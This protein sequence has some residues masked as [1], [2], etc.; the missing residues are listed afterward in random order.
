ME[1]DDYYQSLF[2]GTNDVPAS[3]NYESSFPVQSGLM[4]FKWFCSPMKLKVMV[5]CCL[6]G[7]CFPWLS[8]AAVIDK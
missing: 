6:R 4:Q 8:L 7:F 5:P 1:E 2:R 3:T